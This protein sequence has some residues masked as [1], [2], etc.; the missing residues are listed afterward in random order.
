MS[1]L[2]YPCIKDTVKSYLVIK[3]KHEDQMLT[4]IYTNN[5]YLT[6]SMNETICNWNLES[7]L[8]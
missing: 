8:Q 4:L 3:N 5:L 1:P 2:V 6:A 7:V